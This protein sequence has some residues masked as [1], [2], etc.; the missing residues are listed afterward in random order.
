VKPKGE[1]LLQFF[2]DTHHLTPELAAEEF[3]EDKVWI[4]DSATGRGHFGANDA[5]AVAEPF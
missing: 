4:E 3:A 2:N 1:A 5:T